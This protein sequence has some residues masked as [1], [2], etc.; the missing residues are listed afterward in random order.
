MRHG[1]IVLDASNETSLVDEGFKAAGLSESEFIY[2]LKCQAKGE[3]VDR[4]RIAEIAAE[5]SPHLSIR[6]GPKV[7]AWSAA[8]EFLLEEG[9]KPSGKRRPYL[10]RNRSEEWVDPVTEA[11]RLEFD[12][13]GFDPRPA[14]RR[15]KARRSPKSISI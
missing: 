6:R 1:Q 10:G 11:T 14:R 4:D 9:I 7:T 5:V 8:H 12:V 13:P 2:L 15:V 3:H